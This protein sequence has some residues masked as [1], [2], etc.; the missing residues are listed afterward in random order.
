[1]ELIARHNLAND[2]NGEFTPARILRVSEI[3]WPV[4]EVPAPGADFQLPVWRDYGNFQALGSETGL[5]LLVQIGR[6]WTPTN[7]PA[8]AHPMDLVICDDRGCRHYSQGW[9]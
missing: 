3:G 5:L 8:E 1:V 6:P 9:H 2:A 4:P 7:R